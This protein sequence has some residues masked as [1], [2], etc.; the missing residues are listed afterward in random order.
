MALVSYIN[1]LSEEGRN[2]VRGLG[3]LEEIFNHNDA[4][5]D[6][7]IHTNRQTISNQEV[8][9]DTLVDLAINRIKWYI[10]RK[11]NKEFNPNDY[12]YFFNERIVEFDTIAY[13]I[14]AQAIASKFRP[15]SRE[16]KLFV[17]SQGLMI[18]DRL[19]KMQLSEKKEIVDEI[20]NDFLI[21]DGIEWSF[22]KD[23]VATK[24]LSLTDLVLQ[25][26]EI[27]LDKEE[28]VYSFGDKFSGRVPERVYDILIGD[29]LRELILTKLLMIAHI[30]QVVVPM[31]I[32]KLE[33]LLGKHFL[34]A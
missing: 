11:N 6:I 10:E 1:P 23:L 8:V 30:M 19:I 5:M 7:V 17:E 24:K 13:H 3:G 26:G 28:F 4:L 21:Q 31:E 27:V 9:P 34:H 14:L 29:N 15:G 32:W 16:V 22:L 20:L 25:N 12:N 18:E 2:I 33:S